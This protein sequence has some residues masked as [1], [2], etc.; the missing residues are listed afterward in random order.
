MLPWVK[1]QTLAALSG[2]R[3]RFELN[4]DGSNW[5]NLRFWHPARKSYVRVWGREPP[6]ACGTKCVSGGSGAKPPRKF[7]YFT[8]N[9]WSFLYEILHSVGHILFGKRVRIIKNF[10][11]SLESKKKSNISEKLFFNLKKKSLA[12]KKWP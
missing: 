11:K 5:S 8:P 7:C 1:H 9:I 12:K 10:T 2:L 4:A 6:A 3:I